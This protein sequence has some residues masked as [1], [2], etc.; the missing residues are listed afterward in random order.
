MDKQKKKIGFFGIDL[1]SLQSSR[2]EVINY[3][4]KNAPG[5][6]NIIH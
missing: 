5:L 4:E 2:E 6:L 1:Y 3:L